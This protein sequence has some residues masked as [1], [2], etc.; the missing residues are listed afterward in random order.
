MPNQTQ[1][2]LDLRAGERERDR[3]VLSASQRRSGTLSLA[4]RLAAETARSRDDRTCTADDVQ[5]ALI[6]A[7][8]EPSELGNAAG[9]IFRGAEWEQT[10]EWRPSARVSNHAHRNPVWRM[11]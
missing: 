1:L 11:R 4:R 8:H 9:A 2:V 7:G 10:G 3:G 6:A 5:I